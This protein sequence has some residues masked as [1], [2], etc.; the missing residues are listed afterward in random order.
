MDL[1]SGISAEAALQLVI[2]GLLTLV[3]TSCGIAILVDIVKWALGRSRED[4]D[5]ASPM[6]VVTSAGSKAM[7][8]LAVGGL[9]VGGPTL[10]SATAN[11]AGSHYAGGISGQGVTGWQMPGAAGGGGSTFGEALTQLAEAREKAAEEAASAQVSSAASHFAE[12][13]SNAASLNVAGA[14]TEGAQGIASTLG[15]AVTEG[16]YEIGGGNP[17]TFVLSG[18]GGIYG[19]YSTIQNYFENL[20]E[21]LTIASNS[22]EGGGSHEF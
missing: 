2:G 9:A 10:A 17:L 5:V 15:S 1:L 3:G 6:P 21:A 19:Q 12:A 14:I 4:P 20:Q 8:A 7:V 22:H 11:V 16:Y 13:G 18:G